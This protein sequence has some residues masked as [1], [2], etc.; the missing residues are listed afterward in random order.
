MKMRR[1]WLYLFDIGL[2]VLLA[3]AGWRW[4]TSREG[5]PSHALNLIPGAQMTIQGI[6]WTLA[7]R[8]AVLFVSTQ[9]PACQDNLPLYVSLSGAARTHG[10][11]ARVLFS[12]EESPEIVREW[13]RQAG[14]ESPL[15]IKVDPSELGI[16]RTPTI[17][18]V[19]GKGRVT[20]LTTRRLSHDEGLHLIARVLGQR[21]DPLTR[22]VAIAEITGL[23]YLRDRTPRSITVDIREREH[24]S[25]E[26]IVGSY[27]LPRQ[28][29][30]QR[31]AD[32][33]RHADAIFVD[34]R[35]QNLTDCRPAAEDFAAVGF[36]RVSIITR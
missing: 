22:F 7:D 26:P 10:G 20:D 27:N 29:V 4:I 14:V 24:A 30:R 21:E 3:V 32:E 1:S 5:E 13:L 18:V 2:I 12:S 36:A 33:L 19:N 8:N 31:A 9:C 23:Q 6:D 35:R 16:T 25:A 15:V 17:A 34:C 11:S 28:E